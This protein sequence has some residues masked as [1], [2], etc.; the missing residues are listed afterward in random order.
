M[1]PASLV[2]TCKH[3]TAGFLTQRRNLFRLSVPMGSF[4]ATL[5][6]STT[7]TEVWTNFGPLTT[8]FTPPPRCKTDP[9]K[10]GLVEF[11]ITSGSM[12]ALSY[13]CGQANAYFIQYPECYPSSSGVSIF[14][15]ASKIYGGY[16]SPGLICPSG[17][18]TGYSWIYHPTTAHL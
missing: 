17:W 3:R 13:D 12:T 6:S 8:S 15:T 11:H 18:S 4:T 16:W 2:E 10:E 14:Q 7:V 9:A 1:I 5:T